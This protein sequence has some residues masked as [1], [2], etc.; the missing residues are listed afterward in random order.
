MVCAAAL[1]VLAA[2]LYGAGDSSSGTVQR[3]LHPPTAQQVPP[4]AP[5]AVTPPPQ[6]EP[7]AKAEKQLPPSEPTRLHIPKILVDAPFTPLDIDAKGQLEAPPA[8]N[9]NLV[10]WYAK[11]ASPGEL[12]TSV[13]A[14]HVDT[15]TSAAVFARLRELKKGDVFHVT[16][17]DGLRASF[18]VDSA[19]VFAKDK[20]PDDR[21]YADTHRAEVRLITCA[22]VYDRSAKDYK[23]NLV[24]FAHLV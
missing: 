16:R 13:I 15:T 6:T 4:A 21:V 11:G 5:Q 9:V 12:G 24:V 20:F 10:G 17:A 18:V 3:S 19:E 14:G 2:T 7:P 8:D 22:G 23:E 1:V